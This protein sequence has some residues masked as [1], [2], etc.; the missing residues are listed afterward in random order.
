MSY[1]PLA[2]IVLVALGFALR[3]NAV[4]VV[5]AA[6]LLSG[7]LAGLSVTDVL[8]LIGE[9]F[10]GNRTL[11]LFILTLPAIGVLERSGLR[12]H[13]QAWVTRLR[14]L[15]LERLLIGYLALR[16]LSSMVGLT[17]VLG[18]AQTVRPLLAPMA[19]AAAKDGP[20]ELTSAEAQRV[21][22]MAAAT[23][24][25]G[26]F[27]GEDVFVAIGAVLLIQAFYAQHFIVLEPLAIAL[28]AAPTAGIA[29]VVH[30]VRIAVFARRSKAARA[31]KDT[32]A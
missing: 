4:I 30:A 22:A 26:L 31:E 12:E 6:G 9:T 15:T 25:V 28:W 17:H 16:Q 5:V 18:H 21:R 14:G 10:A 8:A 19:E 32:S 11:L 27:F 3:W 13:A 23:D 24:N 7:L 20:G 2:S 1:W 29:F